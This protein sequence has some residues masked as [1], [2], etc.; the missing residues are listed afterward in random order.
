MIISNP[1]I[2]NVSQAEMARAVFSEYHTELQELAFLLTGHSEMAEA[3]VIDAW[4]IAE[5]QSDA[6]QET[7][8]KQWARHSI[9]S[10]AVEIQQRRIL[11]LACAYHRLRRTISTD[12]TI[13]PEVLETFMLDSPRE[14]M[15]MDVLCRSVL[16]LCVVEKKS[17][18]GAALF[19]GV[20]R[21]AV[22]S[23][24]DAVLRELETIHYGRILDDY[25]Y[26]RARD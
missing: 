13:T 17:F 19:L 3:C 10:A 16:V 11:E 18:A 4:R 24:Y 12:R 21:S 20:S 2:P 23:A 15:R 22:Q 1:N 9:I 14:L 8:S 7:R 6:F 25:E 5:S 26:S